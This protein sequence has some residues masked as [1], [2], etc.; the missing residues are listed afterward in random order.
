MIAM[1]MCFEHGGVY[2]RRTWSFL[3]FTPFFE[4]QVADN[5]PLA[6]SLRGT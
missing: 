1:E 3:L 5:I 4:T 2:S 6:A